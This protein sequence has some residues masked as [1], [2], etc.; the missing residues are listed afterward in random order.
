MPDLAGREAYT[1]LASWAP[2]EARPGAGPALL[3][4]FVTLDHSLNLLRAL[5]LDSKK[6]R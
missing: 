6:G 4:G 3:G 2:D 1:T 5:F